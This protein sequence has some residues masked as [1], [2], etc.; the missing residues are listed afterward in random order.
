MRKR[1]SSTTRTGE[2]HS[3]PGSRQVRLGLSATMVPRPTRIASA[4]ARNRW[5]CARAQSRPSPKWA[6]RPVPA[7][8]AHRCPARASTSPRAALRDAEHVAEIDGKSLLLEHAFVTSMPASRSRANRRLR[9]EGRDRSWRRRPAQAWRLRSRRRKGAAPDM[10]A[11]F[12]RDVE[13]GAVVRLPACSS[14]TASAWGRP[15]GAV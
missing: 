2:R 12:E 1:R 15:P 13:R 14:A 7:A 6:R 11:R 5:A 8:R 9:C 4:R 10:S 3:M